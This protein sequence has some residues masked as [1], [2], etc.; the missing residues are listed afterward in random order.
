MLTSPSFVVTVAGSSTSRIV[1]LLLKCVAGVAAGVPYIQRSPPFQSV[2]VV[3]LFVSW[4]LP[5]TYFVVPAI[6]S[7]AVAGTV[8]DEP[9]VN[10]PPD[11]L[12]SVVIV[13]LLAPA[14]VPPEKVNVDSSVAVAGSETV[15]VLPAIDRGS[16]DS[17]AL[18]VNVALTTVAAMLGSSG[19]QT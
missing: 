10:S 5:V 19:M 16:T 4:W 6:F 13:R 9:P 2:V 15:S 18:I 17:S 14:T 1:P 7:T 11:Q 3:E 8:V 12:N